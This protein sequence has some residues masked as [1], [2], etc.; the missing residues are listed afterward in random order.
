[1]L[2]APLAAVSLP[3]VYTSRR[4]SLPPLSALH[5]PLLPALSTD[6]PSAACNGPASPDT[7]HPRADVPRGCHTAPPGRGR[8]VAAGGQCPE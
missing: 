6:L 5:Q 1:M 3:S 7:S 2:H 8:T 4:L